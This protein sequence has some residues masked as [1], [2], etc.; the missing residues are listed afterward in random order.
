MTPDEVRE[1]TVPLTPLCR[2]VPAGYRLRLA[3]AGADFP[4][5]W[6]TPQ[7]Y[8]L[9]IYY[10][11]RRPSRIELPIV[12]CEGEELPTPS[13]QPAPVNEVLRASVRMD[14][15]HAIRENLMD[16]TVSYE[17]GFHREHNFDAETTVALDHRATAT[18]DA[19]RPWTTTLRAE[20]VFQYRRPA[21]STSM[22]ST[23]LVTPFVVH[24]EVEAD[25]DGRRLFRRNWDKDIHAGVRPEAFVRELEREGGRGQR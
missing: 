18:T 15:R 19:A 4:E 3:L 24:V 9:R 11:G 5:I 20:F 16:K 8:D 17:T 21:G 2:V 10:G 13:L 1:V 23:L 7:P 25:M 6:P 22:R 12:S 14:E